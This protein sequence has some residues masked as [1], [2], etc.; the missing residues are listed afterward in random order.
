MTISG[1]LVLECRL[2]PIPSRRRQSSKSGKDARC[3]APSPQHLAFTLHQHLLHPSRLGKIILGNQQ[4]GPILWSGDH[5]LALIAKD[6]EGFV[7]DRSQLGENRATANAT[8]FVVLDFRLG[9]AHP[10]H[11]PIDVFPT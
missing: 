4:S 3:R 6:L 11:F 2:S 1:L 7:E 5:I 10:I 9:D 8:A